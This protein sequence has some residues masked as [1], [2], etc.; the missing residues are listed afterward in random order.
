MIQE[1]VLSLLNMTR[2]LE[3]SSGIAEIDFKGS[4]GST[5]QTV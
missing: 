2:N 3:C 5:S 1:T 4:R